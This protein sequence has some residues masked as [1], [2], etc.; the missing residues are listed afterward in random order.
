MN[1]TSNTATFKHMVNSVSSILTRGRIV[2]EYNFQKESNGLN[3]ARKAMITARLF[4]NKNGL[5][6]V[7]QPAIARRRITKKH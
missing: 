2:Q 4:L 7:K 1:G 3:F 6:V 5:L